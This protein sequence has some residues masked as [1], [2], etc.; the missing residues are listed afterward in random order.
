MCTVFFS[1]QI[2][3]LFNDFQE[4]SDMLC[5][6]KQSLQQLIYNL[7]MTL[8]LTQLKGF[9]VM[10]FSWLL[11]QTYGKGK[12]Y[13]TCL[14]LILLLEK[15][16]KNQFFTWFLYSGNFTYER[17]NQLK[18]FQ[19]RISEQLKTLKNVMSSTSN[20]YWKCDPKHHIKD[21]TYIEI[22]QL[23]QVLYKCK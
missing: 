11:L 21:V 6:Q 10:Q 15:W 7:Y 13:F 16:Y 9:S 3:L 2:D 14:F 20:L 23:L 12:F 22:T 4:D 18:S 5:D 17:T 1:A 19:I 8:H